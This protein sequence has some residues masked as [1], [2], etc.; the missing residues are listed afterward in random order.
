[1]AAAHARRDGMQIRLVEGDFFD[2]AR[3]PAGHFDV[4]Y[5]GGFIEHFP[6]PENLMQRMS[7]L[8]SPRG[9]VVTSVPNLHG[10][11]GGLQKLVDR[12]C[13]TRHVAFTPSSLDAVHALGGMRPVCATGYVG[14]LALDAVNFSGPELPPLVLKLVFATLTRSHRAAEAIARSLRISHGGLWLSPA[15]VGV[16]ARCTSDDRL[17]RAR[18]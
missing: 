16:Y 15:L 1:M 7:E 17:A 4:I 13:W 10:L 8:L 9:V 12:D 5:S 11:Q 3:L 2:R 18:R 14:V 6:E